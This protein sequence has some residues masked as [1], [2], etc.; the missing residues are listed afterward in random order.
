M[1]IPHRDDVPRLPARR[2]HYD[3]HAVG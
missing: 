1:T 3:D 2:P